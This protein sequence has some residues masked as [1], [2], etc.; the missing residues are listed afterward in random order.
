M[1]QRDQRPPRLLVISFYF[2]PDGSI[3]GQ[4]W[5]GLTKYLAR[6]GW[7]VH[8]VTASDP[9]QHDAT[10]WVQRHFRARRRTLNEAYR[11]LVARRRG[12]LQPPD[13][14]VATG[15]VSS[16]RQ[17]MHRTVASLK[18]V[19]G[20]A[21]GLPDN[22]RGWIMRATGAA[23]ALVRDLDFDY[24]ISSG[25][26][27]S[28][29]IA[30]FLATWGTNTKFWIDMRDPWSLT[31]E[32]NTPLT[33]MIRAERH[34]LYRLERLIFPRA[35]RVLVNT[36]EFAAALRATQSDLKVVHLPN[37]IDA[38]A[39]PAR[40]ESVV[41]QGMI[42][43]VGTLYAGRNLSGVLRAM[44]GLLDQRSGS[45]TQ[46]TLTVAGPL[47]SP[48]G[49]LLHSTVAQNDL[50]SR[51]SVLGSL[52]RARALEILSRSHLALVL[53]QDQPLCVPAK[54]YESVGLGVPTLVIAERDSAAASEARR[55]GAM[56]VEA[57][58]VAGIKSILS[59]LVS[60]KLPKTI[61][62]RVPISYEA[63]AGELDHM[64]RESA[65][66]RHSKGSVAHEPLP[67]FA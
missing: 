60:G 38:E 31:Y 26:P 41:E 47:E 22:G 57:D 7:E 35:S 46:L 16:R 39:L 66:Q 25:P 29:H 58:D 55:I 15:E 33:R 6:A 10:P 5:A 52:P 18:R 44:R 37:G 32:M 8:V 67:R 48:H 54:V 42:S 1:N 17:H 11:A 19:I 12:T 20:S 21:V 4:R 23:S 62:P 43:Y 40:D 36:A 24:V 51:V 56:T 53:A 2:P 14:A 3:G 65:V 64:L 13:D 61:T 30:A 27:H 34:V 63:L 49:E 45:D 28:A 50:G 9:K 59:D